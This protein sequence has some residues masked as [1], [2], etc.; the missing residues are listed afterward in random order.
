MPL[1]DVPHWYNVTVAVGDRL[2]EYPL[3]LVNTQRVMSQRAVPEIAIL[4]FARIEP[5]VYRSVIVYLSAEATD[6]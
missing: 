4:L 1:C 5:L 3:A 6:R 2:S